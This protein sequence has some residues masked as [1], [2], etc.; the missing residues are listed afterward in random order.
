MF[1]LFFHEDI[2]PKGEAE[3]RSLTLYVTIIVVFDETGGGGRLGLEGG[4]A[5]SELSHAPVERAWVEAQENGGPVLSGYLPVRSL[6][7]PGDVF[8]LHFL[9]RP[10]S[11]LLRT[12]SPAFLEPVRQFAASKL[13]KRSQA[14]AMAGRH[15][16][17]FMQ[18]AGEAAAAFTSDEGI[19]ALART[20]PDLDNI[21]AAASTVEAVADPVVALMSHISVGS[22]LAAHSLEEE[23]GA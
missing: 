2:G 6:E 4:P 1:L 12:R 3:A 14:E 16:Q 19:A 9:E 7:R 13:A 18:L 5:D 23:G 10:G 21:R 17:H 11:R 15:A 8:A 22:I 20:A